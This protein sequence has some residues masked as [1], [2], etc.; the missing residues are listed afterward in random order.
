MANRNF[1]L[2]ESFPLFLV[3]KVGWRIGEVIWKWAVL[4]IDIQRLESEMYLQS[5]LKIHYQ[6][7][8]TASAVKR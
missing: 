1:G 8:G 4:G 7:L 2:S 3:E 5:N 6:C